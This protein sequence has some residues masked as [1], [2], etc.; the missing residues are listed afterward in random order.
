MIGATG[1][2]PMHVATAEPPAAATSFGA[3]G[4]LI[5]IAAFKDEATA[6]SEAQGFKAK[7]GELLADTQQI[8]QRADLGEKGVY[9]RVQYGPF[10]SKGA[11]SARC[12]DLKSRGLNCIIVSG[13]KG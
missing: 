9:F 7:G 6:Q 11:A 1:A 8:I 13:G 4:Y 12:A 3:G 2:T 5:Q 10:A